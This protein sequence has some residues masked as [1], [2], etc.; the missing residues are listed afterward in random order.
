MVT[1]PIIGL[2]EPVC[3]NDTTALYLVETDNPD[4]FILRLTEKEHPNPTK[5]GPMLV[6][7]TVVNYSRPT[8]DLFL[9]DLIARFLKQY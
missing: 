8:D 5:T 4:L 1:K 2:V 6:N 9:K 7:E 3:E